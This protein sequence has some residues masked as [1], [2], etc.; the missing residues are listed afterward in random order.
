M[1]GGRCKG[2]LG[3][4]CDSRMLHQR[5]VR[6]AL[7]SRPPDLEPGGSEEGFFSLLA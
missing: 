1:C 4:K 6:S 3:G 7:G 2:P 5:R